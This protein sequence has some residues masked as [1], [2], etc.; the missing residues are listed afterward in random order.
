MKYSAIGT[1]VKFDV[2][3][4]DTETR[5]YKIELVAH[6]EYTR[7]FFNMALMFAEN[8][9]KTSTFQKSIF[10]NYYN[11]LTTFVNNDANTFM[12]IGLFS[13]DVE[14][15]DQGCLPFCSRD[16]V[17]DPDIHEGKLF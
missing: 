12:P 5:P 8:A 9:R 1:A 14:Q 11:S 7:R 13:F 6:R 4:S 16:L 3:I 15:P 2:E 17:P 10:E